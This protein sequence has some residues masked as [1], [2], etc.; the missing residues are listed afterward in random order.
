[1]AAIAKG[2]LD[3]EQQ[4]AV[5]KSF[6]EQEDFFPTDSVVFK[7]HSYVSFIVPF[8]PKEKSFVDLTGCF[9]WKSLQGNECIY[10]L[11]DFDANFILSIPSKNRQAKSLVISWE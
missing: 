7:I 1:M 6:L 5:Y 3:Q 10:V 9:D 11:Y 4:N 2:H 8:T